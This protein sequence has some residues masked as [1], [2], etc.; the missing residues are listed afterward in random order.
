MR[1]T[2][3]SEVMHRAR[4]LDRPIAATAMARPATSPAKWPLQL[5]YAFVVGATGL[6]WTAIYGV[7]LAL[8]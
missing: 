1:A 7:S 5:R 6:L 3:H 2:S 8:I 4:T